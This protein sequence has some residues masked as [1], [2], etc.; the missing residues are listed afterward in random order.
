MK[1]KSLFATALLTVASGL[2]TA[3]AAVGT[4]PALLSTLTND[5]VSILSADE[6]ANTRGERVTTKIGGFEVCKWGICVSVDA[7]YVSAWVPYYID[8]QFVYFVDY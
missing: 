6:S 7:T 2:S 4:T 3:N 8:S 5:S 1:Q